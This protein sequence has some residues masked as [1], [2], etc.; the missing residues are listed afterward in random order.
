M[1]YIPALMGAIEKV[2]RSRTY[3]KH[4]YDEETFQDGIADITTAV[5]KVVSDSEN[6]ESQRKELDN[7]MLYNIEWVDDDM[8]NAAQIMLDAGFRQVGPDLR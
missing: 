8:A 7:I 4:A 3:D 1:S 5:L 6:L 2:L